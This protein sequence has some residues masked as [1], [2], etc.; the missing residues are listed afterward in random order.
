M[1]HDARPGCAPSVSHLH[2]RCQLRDWA[3]HSKGGVLIWRLHPSLRNLEF[4]KQSAY[5]GCQCFN[6]PI[7]IL[8]RH[9]LDVSVW[10][11]LSLRLGRWAQLTLGRRSTQL[12]RHCCFF[13]SNAALTEP[14]RPLEFGYRTLAPGSLWLQ[15]QGPPLQVQ[16][17]S[18]R[19]RCRVLLHRSFSLQSD[20]FRDIGSVMGGNILSDGVG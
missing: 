17:A 15:A 10:R 5:P 9:A 12:G 1:T 4:I 19:G 7:K 3:R 2:R 11:G 20:D 13:L 8:E 16:P 18:C 14:C 6:Q